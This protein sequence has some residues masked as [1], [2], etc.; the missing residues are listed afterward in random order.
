MVDPDPA[1]Y[2]SLI[3]FKYTWYDKHGPG[4]WLDDIKL[5]LM[6]YET[7]DEEP[8]ERLQKIREMLEEEDDA[9]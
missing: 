1:E 8:P 4:T 2:D 5:T 7:R 6:Y 3:S 9:S